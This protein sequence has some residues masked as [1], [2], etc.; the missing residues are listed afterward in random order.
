M[1]NMRMFIVLLMALIG[2]TNVTGYNMVVKNQCRQTIYVG[3][4]AVT[5]TLP[6]RGGFRLD[7]G[8]QQT[9][10]LPEANWNGRFW[11]RTGCDN[12]GSN[13]DTGD[14][15]GGIQCAGRGGRPPA[16][17]AEINFG[18]ANNKAF[19]DVSLVDGYNV[20]MSFG[21]VNA[22]PSGTECGTPT[23]TRD[24]LPS[25]PAQLQVAGRGGRIVACA[26]ACTKFNTD[27]YCCRGAYGTPQSCQPSRWPV[28]YVAAFHAACPRAY[29][30]AYDDT[31]ALF[32][33]PRTNQ[34]WQITFCP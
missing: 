24:L 3:V 16:S 13:C 8:R 33:C 32:T 4:Q 25:C 30:Y 26:S 27:Q 19:Y 20:P 22:S 2:V 12:T 5:G 1:S 14:C 7:A 17:L 23:C 28:N 34:Q 6:E 18:G 31:R 9:V 29:A 11:A 10:T 15:G 21:P